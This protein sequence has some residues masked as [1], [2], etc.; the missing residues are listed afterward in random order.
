MSSSEK[1]VE[2]PVAP[3]SPVPSTASGSPGT[4]ASS[5]RA[6]APPP[7]WGTMVLILLGGFCLGVLVGFFFLAPTPSLEETRFLNFD[8]E[9]TPQGHLVS[10]FS[11][12]EVNAQGD[13]F[14]WCDAQVVRLKVTSRGDGDRTL[15]MRFWP[16]VY[17]NGPQQTVSV[18]VNEQHVGERVMSPE[19]SVVTLRAPASAWRKGD[20]EIRFKFKYAEVPSL[21]AP[22]S[23]DTRSLSAAFDWLE[24]LRP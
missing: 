9:S 14:Q 15:R 13:S 11:L 7:L 4:Q 17:P 10:G 16:F 8:P 1:S 22:P 20:N 19:P 23:T 3:V 5:V 6:E 18:L 24:I 12:S 2:R 21:R